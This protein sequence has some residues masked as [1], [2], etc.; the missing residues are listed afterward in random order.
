MTQIT[1]DINPYA[2]IVNRKSTTSPPRAGW[3]ARYVRTATQK[4]F[5]CSIDDFLAMI[6]RG[7]SLDVVGIFPDY[8]HIYRLNMSNEDAVLFKLQFTSADVQLVSN[9]E[10]LSAY[11]IHQKYTI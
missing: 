1:T 6:D 5:D 3:R 2:I 8:F 7:W 11:K 9:P 4:K 10:S